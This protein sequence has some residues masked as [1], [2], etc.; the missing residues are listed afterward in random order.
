VI[1]SETTKPLHGRQNGQ[2]TAYVKIYWRSAEACGG[3]D[4]KIK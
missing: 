1:R 4:Q 3:A 2:A